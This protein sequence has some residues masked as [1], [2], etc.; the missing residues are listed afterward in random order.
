MARWAGD[1]R[2]DESQFGVIRLCLH[3]ARDRLSRAV[4]VQV[5]Y[6]DR[7]IGIK[8]ISTR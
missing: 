1:L 6:A 2:N 4:V 3:S 7:R 8:R 5:G